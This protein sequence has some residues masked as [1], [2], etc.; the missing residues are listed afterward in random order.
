M[1]H[2]V[3]R[4]EAV[5]EVRVLLPTDRD[6]R[7]LPEPIPTS[8]YGRAAG[9]RRAMVLPFGRWAAQLGGWPHRRMLAVAA[10]AVIGAGFLAGLVHLG[11]QAAHQQS[12]VELAPSGGPTSAPALTPLAAAPTATPAPTPTVRGTASPA[13]V[14]ITLLD[15]PLHAQRGDTVALRAITAPGATCAIA[16]GYASAP[17]LAPAVA[18][19]AGRVSWSWTLNHRAPEGTWPINVSCGGGTASTTITI[20]A[21]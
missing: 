14:P 13:P 17:A 8:Y 11:G 12:S 7:W 4:S 19:G 5:K 18:S 21:D 10:A 20:T 1:R 15:A 16:V 9:T 3:A 6:Q 2:H